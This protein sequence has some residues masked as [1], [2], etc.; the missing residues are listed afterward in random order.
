[1]FLTKTPNFRDFFTIFNKTLRFFMWMPTICFYKDRYLRPVDYWFFR[2]ISFG[3]FRICH[4]FK[5]FNSVV[6]FYFIKV[7]HTFIFFNRSI[8]IFLHNISMLKDSF[9]A[10]IYS[11]I[12][13]VV[14][15]RLVPNLKVKA[16]VIMPSAPMELTKRFRS[17]ISNN[18]FATCYCAYHMCMIQERINYVK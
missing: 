7:M 9:A 10:N 8:N 4:K 17:F 2:M 16:F 3:M 12:S 14:N 15:R 5:I 18:S 1:M 6:G 11:Y 13:I